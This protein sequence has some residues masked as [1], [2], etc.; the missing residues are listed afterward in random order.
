MRMDDEGDGAIGP[1][2]GGVDDRLLLQSWDA[3]STC[4][5]FRLQT[6]GRG[7]SASLPRPPART[8]ARPSASRRRCSAEATSSAAAMAAS[9]R[10]CASSTDPSTTCAPTRSSSG[11]CR[12]SSSCAKSPTSASISACSTISPRSMR[13]G[14]RASARRST[15][16]RRAARTDL[17]LLRRAGL[18]GAGCRTRRSTPSWRARTEGRSRQRPL[19]EPAKIW[20]KVREARRDGYAF[21]TEEALI[22]EVVLS[23]AVL[24]GPGRP[25][26]AVHIAGS[27]RSVA[28]GFPQAVRSLAFEA[29]RALSGRIRYR[30]VGS[31]EGR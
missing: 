22:G 6:R 19:T 1:R 26:G 21:A 4:S 20:R 25:L 15:R 7:R 3:P 29:A 11:R 10:A 16:A 23:A 14:C 27:L 28:R 24:A 31:G 30:S 2:D 12:S 18:P 8:R 9:S 13:R 17:R 5:S